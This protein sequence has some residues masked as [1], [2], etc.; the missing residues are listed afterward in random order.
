MVLLNA[1]I[2]AADFVESH[3]RKIPAPISLVDDAIRLVTLREMPGVKLLFVLRSVPNRL[4]RRRGLP[5]SDNRPLMEQMLDSGFM[6]L[7]DIPDRELVVGVIAPVSRRGRSRALTDAV[8]FAS[9]DLPGHVKIAMNFRLIDLGSSTRLETETR[10][11]A[12]DVASRRAFRRYWL[13]I[14]PWSGLI[15]RIWLRAIAA[16][17]IGNARE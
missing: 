8:D 3:A 17:A 5:T 15:H 9:F 11:V 14:R 13:L 4:Q 12:T 16:R 1:L 7:A 10:V 6:L 2:P